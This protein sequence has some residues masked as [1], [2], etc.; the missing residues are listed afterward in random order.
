[1]GSLTQAF[2]ESRCTGQ[3]LP[4][5]IHVEAYEIDSALIP[6]LQQ[7]MER[8]RKRC[9]ECGVKFSAEIHNQDFIK[10]AAEMARDDFFSS[11]K[12]LFNA[13][14]LNPPYRKISSDSADREFLRSAGIE[15]SN[16]Y[17]GFLALAAKLLCR[18]GEMVAI[19]PRSFANGPYFRPFREV[20]LGLM[21]LRQLHIFDSRSAAFAQDKVLQEN[22]ILHAVKSETKPA[23]IFVSKSSGTPNAPIAVRECKY[24][25]IISPSDPEKFI[26]LWTD[27]SQAKAR[28]LVSKLRCKLADLG[29]E[30]S[31]GR[32]VDFRAKQALQMLPATNTVPLIYPCHF[33]D[34]YVAWPKMP[35]RKPNALAFGKDTQSLMVPSAIYVLTK[36]F[37]AKEERR[38]VVACI[39]DPTRIS[40][41]LVGFENHLNY[42]HHG[43]NGL[44]LKFARGLAA[45]LNSTVLDVYF[46][47]FNGHTQ[48]NATDLRQLPYPTSQKL[49]ALGHA[50]GSA[51]LNQEELDKIVHEELLND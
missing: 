34:G 13:T 36:R 50:I 5:S 22:I 16:L 42:F 12:P 9:H 48:V 25:E 18:D 32:V 6:H 15:T 43:G 28:Q 39:Y 31:T 38:R 8:C 29:L 2:I 37:S 3:P 23:T 14:I 46:R 30:V 4:E 21:S 19:T 17:T 35:S 11:P 40:S 1:M 26:H 41:K 49:E 27:D 45:Y 10:M 7:T 20:F 33:K 51:V 44:S 24:N 47:Q